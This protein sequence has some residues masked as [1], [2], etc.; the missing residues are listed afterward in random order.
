M[1]VMYGRVR[2]HA[3]WITDAAAL[4]VQGT[5]TRVNAG[6]EVRSPHRA[7]LTRRHSSTWSSSKSPTRLLER[8][9]CSVAG[10]TRE[11]PNAVRADPS[12]PGYGCWLSGIDVNT[13]LTNQKFNDPYLAV[14]VSLPF[15]DAANVRSTPTVPC[16]PAR[17]RSEPSERIQR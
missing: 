10:I 12:H 13:Q 8:M 11:W 1:G 17:W 3:F 2:D 5:E 7:Q 15:G 6:N 9:T 14:V 16:R 4:P